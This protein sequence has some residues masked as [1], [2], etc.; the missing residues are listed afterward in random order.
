MLKLKGLKK[1]LFKKYNQ[2]RKL[3]ARVRKNPKG[4]QFPKKNH[5]DNWKHRSPEKQ[6][7]HLLIYLKI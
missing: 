6:F 1:K 3:E 7:S 2:E 5:K 4:L